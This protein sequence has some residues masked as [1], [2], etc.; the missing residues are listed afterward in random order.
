MEDDNRHLQPVKL[1]IIGSET[2]RERVRISD[3]A[4]ITS[5]TAD[6]TQYVVSVPPCH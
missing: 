4:F 3:I 6:Q 5:S 1:D 2:G